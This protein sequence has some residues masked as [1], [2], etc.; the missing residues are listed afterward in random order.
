QRDETQA[1]RQSDEGPDAVEASQPPE[2]VEEALEDSH[3]E[4]RQ[5]SDPRRPALP[6]DAGDQEPDGEEGPTQRV[7]QVLRETRGDVERDPRPA[8]ERV[9]DLDVQD[10]EE[11][12]RRGGGQER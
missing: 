6:D 1:D 11:Q 4:E 5:R 8:R 3:D 12:D 7:S 9:G 10:E 2:I